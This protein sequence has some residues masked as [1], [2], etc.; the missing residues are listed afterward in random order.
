MGNEYP[1]DSLPLAPPKAGQGEG[2]CLRRCIPIQNFN[3]LIK[4][5]VDIRIGRRIMQSA[6]CRI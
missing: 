2:N 3:E 5:F 6:E 4:K 1:M